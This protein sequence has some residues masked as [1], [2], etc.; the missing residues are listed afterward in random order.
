[1][2]LATR[3]SEAIRGHD[4]AELSSM[5]TVFL[6]AGQHLCALYGK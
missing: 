3:C 1:M 6:L 2:G 5:V 4:A